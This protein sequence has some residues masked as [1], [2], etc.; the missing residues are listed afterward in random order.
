MQADF[1]TY[2]EI[3]FIVFRKSFWGTNEK[4]DEAKEKKKRAKAQ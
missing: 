2:I 4:G 1:W 3:S